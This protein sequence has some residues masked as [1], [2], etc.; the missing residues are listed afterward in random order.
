MAIPSKE[1][2]W[3]SPTEFRVVSVLAGGSGVPL[4]TPSTK[5]TDQIVDRLVGNL[6]ERAV[7]P[8][9]ALHDAAVLGLVILTPE[10]VYGHA[11]V[12]FTAPDQRLRIERDARRHARTAGFPLGDPL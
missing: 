7:A 12:N 11:P 9:W 6:I 1:L 3:L 10:G 8:K 5:F 2:S 4:R